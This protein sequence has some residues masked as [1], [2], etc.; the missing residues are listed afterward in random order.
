M[1]DRISIS[2]RANCSDL[3]ASPSRVGR[4]IRLMFAIAAMT[5]CKAEIPASVGASCIVPEDCPDDLVCLM[6]VIGYY[7]D[8]N[9]TCQIPCESHTDCRGFAGNC[10][11][12]ESA[13]SGGFCTSGDCK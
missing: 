10:P 2:T 3:G 5:T 1:S 4:A 6:G 11:A 8:L 13:D 7:E 9:E 12:C